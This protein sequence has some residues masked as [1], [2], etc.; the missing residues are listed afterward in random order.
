MSK[1]HPPRPVGTIP[2][3]SY[4]A[5]NRVFDALEQN[6]DIPELLSKEF[7]NELFEP[8]LRSKVR[9]ACRFLSL[10]DANNYTTQE[11]RRIVPIATRKE[12]LRDLLERKYAPILS[13]A[14]RQNVTRKE[15][16]AAFASAFGSR[17]DTTEK[18]VM[19]F[20]GAADY[21]GLPV[22]PSMKYNPNPFART[23]ARSE[24]ADAQEE[25]H[26]NGVHPASNGSYNSSSTSQELSAV[27]S[28]MVVQTDLHPPLGQMT[29]TVK[30]RGGGMLTLAIAV[31]LFELDEEERN[32]VLDL[33]DKI[34]KHSAKREDQHG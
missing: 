29:R 24:L 2:N 9:S 15:V 26:T 21:A 28:S 1:L 30:L 14:Q 17:G 16:V 27:Q 4:V 18:A 3:I 5:L 13:T 32:F 23:R 10:L 12:V 7:W 11:L 34:R 20:T 33:I 22:A 8:S 6:A 25:V 31:D 19:F